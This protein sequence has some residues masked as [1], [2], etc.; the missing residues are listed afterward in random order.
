MLENIRRLHPRSPANPGICV[1]HDGAML[2]PDYVLVDRTRHGFRSISREAALA[3]QKC[4]LSGER[5]D[6]WLFRQCERISDAL[7]KGEVALAQIYGLR[8]SARR[9]DDR[10]LKRLAGGAL[11]KWTFN[12]DEPRVPKGDPHGGE[13][14]TGGDST[15][16]PSLP[17]VSPEEML[18]D[19]PTGDDANG[20]L[21]P[22]ASGVG[23]SSD[24]SSG[25]DGESDG[26]SASFDSSP[27]KF[28]FDPA[29]S[30][31]SASSHPDGS[32]AN[33][34]L[35]VP[36][37]AALAGD[38]AQWMASELAPTTLDA[39]KLLMAR[40]SGAGIVFGTLFIPTDSGPIV[41]GQI[42][43]S[44]DLSYRYDSDTGILQ[45][46]Q[47]IGSLGPVVFDEAH[48]G[49][50]GL[51]RDAQGQVIGRFLSGGGVV[52][53]AGALLGHQAAAETDQDQPKLC[54]DPNAEN[55]AGRSERSLAYQEE[56]TGLPRGLEVALNG[57]RFDGCI[58]A[59]GTMLEAK[60][61]G[62]EN[63]MDGPDDWQDWFTGDEQLEAQMERQSDAVEGTGRKVEWHFAEEPV[64]DFF[65]AYAEKYKL[66][67][68]VAIYTPPR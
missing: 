42:T 61:P 10:L 35:S 33:N 57:V 17:F 65:R 44:P 53:D 34:N 48:I 8:I 9:L 56:I 64:A 41:E 55:I 13:W 4:V 60:G 26:G 36:A 3:L 21:T 46:R 18:A 23:S 22:D 19:L 63:K 5:D 14:T 16:A 47:D 1:D 43:G 25:N 45:L 68:I 11:T 29:N 31:P 12:P 58:E 2:G 67:N 38:E 32:A 49:T 37:I 28:E 6:D 52:I 7:N 15:A 59:D 24:S 62:F 54:P 39:L 51:F 50:D 66:T 27:L 30:S 40:M 20:T